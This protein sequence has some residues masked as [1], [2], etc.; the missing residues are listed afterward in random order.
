MA[1]TAADEQAIRG[2]RFHH[3]P[4]NDDRVSEMQH[5][6][7]VQAA[8]SALVTV[9]D[10]VCNALRAQFGDS[11]ELRELFPMESYHGVAGSMVVRLDVLACTDQLVHLVLCGST[12]GVQ[13]YRFR[14][15][16]LD[17]VTKVFKIAPELS[18]PVGGRPVL[19]LPRLLGS[20]HKFDDL[21]T[22]PPPRRNPSLPTPTPVAGWYP[23][24]TSRH[25]L[26]YWDGTM[27]TPNASDDGQ[28]VNDPL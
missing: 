21:L 28:S 2:V 12:T 22:N 27:W 19:V 24:P 25:Q 4:G 7:A 9:A 16:E 17:A 23:D 10:G 3:R 14:Y 5:E 15:G 26:R 8:N 13:P 6:E 18:A 11:E 20:E 1:F